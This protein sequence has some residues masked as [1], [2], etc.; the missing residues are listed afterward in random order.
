VREVCGG[1]PAALGGASVQQWKDRAV[2]IH[3]DGTSI[4]DLLIY[5]SK[6]EAAELRDALTGLLENFDDP[7]WHAHV[8]TPDSLTEVTVAPEV[9]SP[10]TS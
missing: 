6:T 1:R 3:G 7:G 9:P 8:S 5:L 10:E 4:S 2:Q